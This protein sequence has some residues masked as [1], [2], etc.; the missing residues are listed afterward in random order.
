[1]IDDNDQE[2]DVEDI[3]ASIKNILEEDQAA[4]QAEDKVSETTV[5]E[6]EIDDILELSPDMRLVSDGVSENEDINLANELSDVEVP[7]LAEETLSFDDLSVEAVDESPSGISLGSE[8]YESDPF[9]EENGAAKED[10][11]ENS[12]EVFESA[13]DISEPAIDNEPVVRNKNTVLLETLV[14]DEKTNAVV[15]DDEIVSTES[16]DEAVADFIVDPIAEAQD[17]VVE[18]SDNSI[19]ASTDVTSNTDD[20]VVSTESSNEAVAD[21]IVEPIA[22]AQEEVIENSDNSIDASADIISNFAKMFAQEAPKPEIVASP[23]AEP[24]KILGDGSKTIEDVVSSVIMQI[25]GKE[26]EANW[27]SGLDYDALARQEIQRQT[28]EWIDNNLPAVVEEI[29][30]REIERVMAKVGTGQ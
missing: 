4:S 26:V 8:D 1:M 14:E 24:I 12:S 20:E 10:I 3:L 7:Q 6:T 15:A 16:S 27:K 23:A 11:I 17:E 18:D 9:Y 19:N 25:I 13:N 22:E 2:M 28:K 29:V 30:K 5:V 21:F